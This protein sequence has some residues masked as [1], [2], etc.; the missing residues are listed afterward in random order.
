MTIE[1]ANLLFI[2]GESHAPRLLGALGNP[3]IKTPNLDRLADSGLLF[4]SAYCASPLCVPARAAIATGRFPHETGFWESSMAFDGSCSSWMKQLRDAGYT[5]VGIGKM[6]FRSDDDDNGFSRF[7]ETMHI[8][9]GVG[10]LVGALRYDGSEPAYRGLWELWTS[11]YGAGDAGPYRQ[12]DERI[13]TS[14]I[15]WLRREAPARGAPWALSVHFIAAH[16]PFVVPAKY[17]ALYDPAELPLPT[18]FRQGQR[19]HPAI[20]HFRKIMCHDDLTIDHVQLVRAAY[21]ATISYLDHLVGRLLQALDDFGLA[22]STRIVYTSDHGFSCGDH[23]LFG[24]FHLYEESLGVPLIMAGPGINPRSRL[25]EPVSHVDLYPTLL[26][27][28]GLSRAEHDQVYSGRSLWPLIE[29]R[30]QEPKPVFAEYHGCCSPAG[31]FV[32]R[33]GALKLVYF[34]GMRPQLFDLAADPDEAR[35]LAAEAGCEKLV[36]GMMQ[37]LRARVDP[38]AIDAKA[39]KAQRALIE[40]H[41]G[42]KA[43]LREKGGFSYS[44]PPGMHWREM[45]P[46]RD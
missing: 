38:E 19:R 23:D 10:D 3:F 4:E 39:K 16:A 31:G 15:D 32:L 27:A 41:G 6:H 40:A 37:R 9:D 36:D 7:I 42:K 45:N 25:A 17:L 1:A 26:E 8:A 18:C 29:G 28:G 43:V 5:T 21:F 24:L 20:E 13:V 30:A 35:D 44:P 33:D 34:V 22:D 14:A 12:Y 46:D 2:L 11:R